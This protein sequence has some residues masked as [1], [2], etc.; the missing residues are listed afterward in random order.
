MGWGDESDS[1]SDREPPEQQQQAVIGGSGSGKAWKA[2]G[3]IGT[4]GKSLQQQARMTTTAA[5]GGGAA[6]GGGRGRGNS[7]TSSGT[8]SGRGSGR[9]SGSGRTNTTFRDNNHGSTTT[10][11]AGQYATTAGSIRDNYT[12]DRDDNIRGGGG[13]GGRGGGR[14]TSSNINTCGGGGRG[15]GGGGGGGG[16]L[17]WK[18]MAKN[19]SK[20]AQITKT[21]AIPG[22]EYSRLETR[23]VYHW[24]GRKEKRSRKSVVFF[25][26]LCLVVFLN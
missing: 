8:S 22:G 21:K 18:E 14:S 23:G 7:G 4:G 19:E 13:G 5:A 1:D 17:N 16:P 20:I 3:P 25:C 11:A 15:R 12:R 2:K 6:T 10:R 9:G 26:V 24:K